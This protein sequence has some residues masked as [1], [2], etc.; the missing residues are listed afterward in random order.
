[1]TDKIT[2]ILVKNKV[3]EQMALDYCQKNDILSPNYQTQTRDGCALCPQKKAEA[4][5]KW[6]EDYPQAFDLLLN[7][8]NIV[9]KERPE[10]YPL[11]NKKFFIEKD[12]QM[13][14]FSD[15]IKYKIN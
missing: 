6:F 3:V 4:R 9:K 13:A 2:S 15:E 8:Q 5:I 7:L 14:I 11:R 1:M 12:P 10:Q